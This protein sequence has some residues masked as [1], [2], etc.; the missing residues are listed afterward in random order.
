MKPD[1]LYAE[2]KSL[3]EKLGIKV[4]EQ[5]FRNVGIHVKSGHC[6]VKGE[7]QCLIDKHI[8]LRHKVDVLSECI[9]LF[10]HE[11]VY[12]L[13]AVREYIKLYT[14]KHVTGEASNSEAPD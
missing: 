10:E 5:N 7:D 14:Q 12:V 2:L 6:I 11:N 4:L 3:A 13:P 8:K 9:A 1:K